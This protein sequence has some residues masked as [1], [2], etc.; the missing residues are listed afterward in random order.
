MFLS[1]VDQGLEK[2]IT[3]HIPFNSH[4]RGLPVYPEKWN[5][6][7][8]QTLI[9]CINLYILC[10]AALRGLTHHAVWLNTRILHYYCLN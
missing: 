4:N 7:N 10:S 1:K 5:Y 3:Q 2:K 6:I 8:L 9:P